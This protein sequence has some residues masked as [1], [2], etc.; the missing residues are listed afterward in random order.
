MDAILHAEGRALGLER[1]ERPVA[2]VG[3]DDR[4]VHA[5]EGS[6]GVDEQIETLLEADPPDTQH[7]LV[8]GVEAESRPQRSVG[9]LA[10]GAGKPFEPDANPTLR[11]PASTSW[12]CS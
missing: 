8:V 1:S 12:R 2:V 9:R 5:V 11:Q 10:G 4:E 7:E 6:D 3:A